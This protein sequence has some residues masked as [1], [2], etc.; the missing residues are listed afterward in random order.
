MNNDEQDEEIFISFVDEVIQK[1]RKEGRSGINKTLKDI[2]GAEDISEID[3]VDPKIRPSVFHMSQFE[4]G[5]IYILNS[6]AD[7]INILMPI[8]MKR[9]LVINA[10]KQ[11]IQ[12]FKCSYIMQTLF[13]SPHHQEGNRYWGNPPHLDQSSIVKDDGNYWDNLELC[14]KIPISM[15][16]FNKFI[17]WNENPLEVK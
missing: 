8:T 5:Y 3:V 17:N 2:D 10:A 7:W 1:L 9:D 15:S 16:V 14:L 11:L 13:K 4:V 12:E 6:N